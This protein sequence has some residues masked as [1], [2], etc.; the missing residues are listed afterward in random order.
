M[1]TLSVLEKSKNLIFELLIIP[2]TLDTNNLRPTIAKSINLHTIR[3]L[4]EYSFKTVIVKATFI[5]T[6]FEILLFE[7]RSVLP[8][9]QWDTGSERVK[10]S[11]KKQKKYSDFVENT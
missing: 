3:K 1:L 2:K 4:I 10:V 7:A 5:V 9:S 6:V 8:P 11:V